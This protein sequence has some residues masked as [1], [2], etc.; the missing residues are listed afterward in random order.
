MADASVH[1]GSD[2]LAFLGSNEL[3]KV[4]A[5][6]AIPAV[7]MLVGSVVAGLVRP[8]K[9]TQAC[10]QNL[11]AGIILAAV[12]TELFPALMQA[13][14]GMGT[15]VAIFAGFVAAVALLFGIDALIEEEEEEDEDEDED[16]DTEQEAQM[17]RLS[18]SFSAGGV[19]RIP[20]R[21]PQLTGKAKLKKAVE[22]SV[23]AFVSPQSSAQHVHTTALGQCTSKRRWT[24]AIQHVETKL[25]EEALAKA[26]A[27]APPRK[28][29]NID[30]PAVIPV[31]VDS[32]VDGFLCGV[33][34]IAK[35]QAGLI[36][37]GATCIEMGFLGISYFIGLKKVLNTPKLFFFTL[38]APLTMLAA[39]A[40]AGSIGMAI[41]ETEWREHQP[42]FLISSVYPASSFQNSGLFGRRYCRPF[43][44]VCL[45]GCACF[46]TFPQ[47]SPACSRS[48]LWR[49]CTWSPRSCS[50]KPRR[51]S[52]GRTSSIRTC[53]SS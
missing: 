11:S 44:T 5:L 48:E 29:D 53:A 32:A 1:A 38:L 23:A 10:F 40:V 19:P 46:I 26:G 13:K 45:C 12:G 2:P 22:R 49:C 8:G 18:Q 31:L 42:H 28:S 51:T 35:P 7:A 30:W 50:L 27:V 36:M 25:T 43:L 9:I 47:F 24:A 52:R 34:Y 37:A 16:S 39:G 21:A 3:V 17:S 20:R 33:A 4:I 14:G 41:E 15:T 6:V